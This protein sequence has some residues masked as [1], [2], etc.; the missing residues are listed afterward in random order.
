MSTLLIDNY[1]SFTY[2][3][4]H[5]LQDVAGIK[6]KIDVVYNDAVKV[7]DALRYDRIVVSPGPGIPKEAGN[8]M[9]IIDG[10]VGKRPFLGI[11]LGHQAMAAY[12]GGD[13]Y[14]LSHPLHGIAEDICL[15]NSR[16]FRGMN[17]RIQVARYHSWIV[18]R[19]SLSSCISVVAETDAREV[20]AIEHQ[21]YPMIGLQFHP[22]SFV[23]SE[24]A[25][26]I[27]NFY[28]L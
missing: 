4:Y 3:L 1:D 27:Q 25:T 18:N 5:L 2:N 26:I 7:K 20:M 19:A 13:L 16:I 10:I 17:K 11:C 23:T 6:E 15:M 28:R 21:T 22:E 14:Q 24:G 9:S 8:L 12:F